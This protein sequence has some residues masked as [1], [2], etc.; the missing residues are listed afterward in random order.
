MMSGEPPYSTGYKK[1]PKTTQF[2][3][4]VSGNPSG[5]PKKK[6]SV[7]DIIYREFSKKVRIKEGGKVVHITLLEAVIKRMINH[8]ATTHDLKTM[9]FLLPLMSE[10]QKANMPPVDLDATREDLINRLVELLPS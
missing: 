2:K 5:R 9:K 1:P 10:G 4:G 3:K 8:T 6:T 7:T